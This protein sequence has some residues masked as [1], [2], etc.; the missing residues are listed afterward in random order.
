MFPT[1]DDHQVYDVKLA[2]ADIKAIQRL[3]GPRTKKSTL[4]TSA[5]KPGKL[6][7]KQARKAHSSAFCIDLHRQTLMAMMDNDHNDGQ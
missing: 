7:R 5:S 1:I 3:Y 6:L 2:R 4:T